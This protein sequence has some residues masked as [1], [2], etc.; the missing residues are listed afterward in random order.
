MKAAKWYGTNRDC[1]ANYEC[2][3]STPMFRSS[4]CDVGSVH[5][6]SQGMQNIAATL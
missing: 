3:R 5:A 6:V 1:L 4:G 2:V